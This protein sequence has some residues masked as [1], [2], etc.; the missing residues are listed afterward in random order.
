M[1]MST[2]HTQENALC[3][4]VCGAPTNWSVS[5]CCSRYFQIR[6]LHSTIYRT[7]IISI[8]T[9]AAP[10]CGYLAAMHKT[11]LISVLN[12]VWCCQ[13]YYVIFLLAC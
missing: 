9:Y 10:I 7:Y 5:D 4:F 6:R 2:D 13:K 1:N 3:S 12:G 8:I 11:K